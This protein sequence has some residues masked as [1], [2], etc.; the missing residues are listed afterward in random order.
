MFNFK[1]IAS[2]ESKRR[3]L[4]KMKSRKIIWKRD[5]HP[6]P[7]VVLLGQRILPYKGNGNVQ[8]LLELEWPYDH[9]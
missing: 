4:G 5:A 2:Q 6:T 9:V 3:F 7:G 8:P 1:H